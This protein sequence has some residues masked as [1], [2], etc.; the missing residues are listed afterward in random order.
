MIKWKIK[1][2]IFYKKKKKIVY[3]ANLN[4][5]VFTVYIIELIRSGS[6]YQVY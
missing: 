6:Y 1:L 2:P 5:L 4:F 3:F